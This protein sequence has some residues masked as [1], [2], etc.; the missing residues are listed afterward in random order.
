MEARE[1]KL[2]L[3][4][5][6]RQ[7][8]DEDIFMKHFGLMQAHGRPRALMGTAGRRARPNRRFTMLIVR[9]TPHRQ[10]SCSMRVALK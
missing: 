10:P 6:A 4:L 2:H 9:T 5:R 7:R 3:K 1:E 8:H